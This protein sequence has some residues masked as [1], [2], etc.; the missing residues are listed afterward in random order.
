MSADL[1][2]LAESLRNS[3]ANVHRLSQE[4]KDAGCRVSF[5]STEIDRKNQPNGYGER[6]TFYYLAMPSDLTVKVT[7]TLEL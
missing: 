7:R 5:E 6:R 3:L 1:E 4:L 2:D